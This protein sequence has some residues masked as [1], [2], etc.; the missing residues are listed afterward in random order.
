M[1][2]YKTIGIATAKKNNTLKKRLTFTKLITLFEVIIKGS[3]TF[4]GI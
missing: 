1:S 3:N 2:L 4:I